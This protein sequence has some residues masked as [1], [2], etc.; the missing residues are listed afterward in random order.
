MR[1]RHRHDDEIKWV[2]RDNAPAGVEQKSGTPS[3]PISYKYSNWINF[4]IS[5]RDYSCIQEWRKIILSHVLFTP[6][7]LHFGINTGI[8]SFMLVA[9]FNFSVRDSIDT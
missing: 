4:N 2:G 9:D 3:E 7:I 8:Q 6:T 5:K 1:A